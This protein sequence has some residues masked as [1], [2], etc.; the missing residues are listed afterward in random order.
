[1][2]N[3]KKLLKKKAEWD[4]LYK[5]N[6]IR[7]YPIIIL[8]D[9]IYNCP[10]IND[11]VNQWFAVELK[12]IENKYNISQI[13]K[14]T[15]INIDVFI[16]YREFLQRPEGALDKLIASYHSYTSNDILKKAT[17]EQ[18]AIKNTKIELNLLSIIY[19]PNLHLIIRIYYCYQAKNILKND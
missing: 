1:M 9:N 6:R 4:S 17:S 13:E 19:L 7:I 5:E 16:A 14:I 15:I 18:D 8:H 11:L 12:E 3:I 10:G 2:H